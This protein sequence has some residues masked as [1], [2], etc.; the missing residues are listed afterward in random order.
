MERCP[1]WWIRVRFTRIPRATI[2][3]GAQERVRWLDAR[4]AEMD[5]WVG[6]RLAAPSARS[7]RPRGRRERRRDSRRT[8]LV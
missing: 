7:P 1:R 6:A 3:A 8:S 4:S 2:P 5:D